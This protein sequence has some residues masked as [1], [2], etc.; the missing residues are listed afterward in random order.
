MG[1]WALRA[2]VQQAMREAGARY[3]K[4]ATASAKARS[5]WHSLTSAER[6]VATLIGEGHTNKSAA[7]ELGVSVSTVTTH[8][9]AI[10]AKLGIQSRVQL[11]IQLHKENSS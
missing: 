6:R 1:A 9:R 2:Q 3:P 8:L 10:F 11:A 7:S 5:G 4:W